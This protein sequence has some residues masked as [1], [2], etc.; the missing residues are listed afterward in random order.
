M[1]T[2]FLKWIRGGSVEGIDESRK[3][4]MRAIS[5]YCD[6]EAQELGQADPPDTADTAD[7]TNARTERD[8]KLS[9]FLGSGR[10]FEHVIGIL[11]AHDMKVIDNVLPQSDRDSRR[12][13]LAELHQALK[14]RLDAYLRSL[15]ELADV[16][17]LP[18]RR[19]AASHDPFR[20]GG[21]SSTYVDEVA[22][23]VDEVAELFTAGTSASLMQPVMALRIKR[24]LA[25][26][27]LETPKPQDKQ[28]GIRGHLADY[29]RTI[30]ALLAATAIDPES[31][32]S[33]TLALVRGL[34]IERLKNGAKARR[35]WFGVWVVGSA[36]G[37]AA[38]VAAFWFSLFDP[39]GWWWI[40][41]GIAG[42]GALVAVLYT[43][44]ATR[45]LSIR[46][47]WILVALPALVLVV[48]LT[49]PRQTEQA[50]AITTL[51]AVI[52]LA[53]IGGVSLWV[54]RHEPSQPRLRS[55]LSS[56]LLVPSTSPGSEENR[57]N[58]NRYLVAE[59]LAMLRDRILREAGK[60]HKASIAWATTFVVLGFLA[61]ALSGAAGVTA[62]GQQ[63]GLPVYFAIAGAGLTALTTALNPGR[64][65]EQA[66]AL[67]LACQ[68][69]EQEVSVLIRLDL[70]G[71]D[72]NRQ[73]IEQISTL[74]DTLLGLPER[75]RLWRPNTDDQPQV[76]AVNTAG[77]P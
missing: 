74:Y 44:K 48:A 60:Q 3:Q 71:A 27:I 64:R 10:S 63:A 14:A 47:N 36:L 56:P 54:V 18:R 19:Q 42:L 11:Q 57:Q 40:T 75:P 45:G 35:F 2:N 28:T 77:K 13:S 20:S 9:R 22:T 4:L 31:V 6:A 76:A 52:A 43:L 26:G 17:D 55:G 8:E 50:L 73:K 70:N 7:L 41:F 46:A 21:W 51:F 65:W 12:L 24:D 69:L 5:Q 38:I 62:A 1:R 58:W 68:S 67:Q 29:D 72:E 33:Q 37:L 30:D 66:H 39:R 53:V 32:D 23:Y 49:L 16:L 59:E 15:T 25:L 34:F 61:A